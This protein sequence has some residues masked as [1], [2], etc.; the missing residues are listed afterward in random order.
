MATSDYSEAALLLLRAVLNFIL[1]LLPAIALCLAAA[2]RFTLDTVQLGCVALAATAVS[3]YCIFWCWFLSWRLV[4]PL[5]IA[6][7]VAALLY[8]V[9]IARRLTQQDRLVLKPMIAPAALIF[10]ASVLVL[11]ATYAYGGLPYN[12]FITAGSR[13]SHQLPLD[14]EIP[15][16]FAHSMMKE[17]KVPIPIQGNWHASDRPPLQSAIVMGQYFGLIGPIYAGYQ[18]LAVFLQ[19]L[20]IFGLWLLLYSFGVNR[21][22][23]SLVLAGSLFSN[24]IFV[25]S[26][27]VWPKLLAASY[28][29]GFL[30]LLFGQRF[31]GPGKTRVF[32]AIIAGVLVAWSMLSHGGTA[33]ACLGMLP[34]VF[35]YRRS[36]PPKA[37]LTALL[38]AAVLYLPWILFQKFVDPPGDRLIK[39]H[40][41][42]V[43]PIDSRSP[44]QAILEAYPA[45]SFS[46]II[47]YKKQNLERIFD[48]FQFWPTLYHFLFEWPL[49]QH[50]Q[51]Q[52]FLSVAKDLNAAQFFFFPS[53]LGLFGLGIPLLALGLSPYWRTI[54]WRAAVLLFGFTVFTDIFWSLL[55]LGPATT[56]LH[57]GSYATVVASFAAG[58]LGLWT[59]SR[60]LA[61]VITLAQ[62]A[63]FSYIHFFLL[64]P[65]KGNLQP[66]MTELSV[67]GIVGTLYLLR[68][69]CGQKVNRKASE[70]LPRSPEKALS[71]TY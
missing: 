16:T 37:M 44:G 68:R 30:A 13:F 6:A 65:P 10:T 56:S 69:V 33:F 43:E 17:H 25:N 48:T 62:V 19:S 21:Y 63:L 50:A 51:P 58:I 8:I 11:S 38:T 70:S 39:M 7:E 47:D 2:R 4:R 36:F 53:T 15:Y 45:L 23:I 1:L 64:V 41:A 24:F 5:G 20:W 22:A 54:E 28:L 55:M 35:L 18:V 27:F 46:Q 59:V 60:W 12:V 9:L 66:G 26:A 57:A 61:L 52:F 31:S 14:D 29:L 67:L 71:A 49:D 34:A 40:F 3:G 32:M 42:G